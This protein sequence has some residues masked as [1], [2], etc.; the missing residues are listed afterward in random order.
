MKIFKTCFFIFFAALLLAALLYFV[1]LSKP[2]DITLS[3]IESSMRQSSVKETK[4]HIKGT[5][6]SYLFQSDRF[7]GQ[8]SLDGYDYTF[9]EN[10]IALSFPITD[11]GTDL[12]YVNEEYSKGFPLESITL[13]TLYA[14]DDFKSAVLLIMEKD[15]SGQDHW[16]K[17]KGKFACFP[18]N[19][20]EEALTMA[21][22]YF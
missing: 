21:E 5:Y 6:T 4:L 2:I 16:N 18:A 1:P 20:R 7:E 11:S 15:L 9:N 8:L 19:T 3:G 17:N 22:E 10:T 14:K 12:R 13:G